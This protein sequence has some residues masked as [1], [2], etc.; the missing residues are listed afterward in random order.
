M[1]TAVVY[2]SRYGFT[3]SYA[4]WISQALGAALL[5]GKRLRSGALSEF[6]TVVFGGGVYAGTVNGL[7]DFVRLLG[8]PAGKRIFLFTVG[9]ADPKDPGSAQS[10]RQSCEKA[11]PF[12]IPTSVTLFHLRGGID[13]KRLNPADRLKLSVMKF[14]LSLMAK[15]PNKG[16]D[17]LLSMISRSSDYRDR[18]AAGPMIELIRAFDR[19]E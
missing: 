9:I 7:S 12:G 13:W 2:R 10:L 5:D 19:P 11:F 16:A 15:E 6:D 8:K 17:A 4:E 18:A 3:K 14:G 1:K